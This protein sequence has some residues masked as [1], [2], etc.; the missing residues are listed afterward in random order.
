M[1]YN[2]VY[3]SS[4]LATKGPLTVVDPYHFVKIISLSFTCNGHF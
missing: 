2:A 1:A 4:I 3:P